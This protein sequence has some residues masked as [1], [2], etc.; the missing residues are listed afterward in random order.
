MKTKE[1]KMKTEK[2]MAV[3]CG[4]NFG[5]NSIYEKEATKLGKLLAEN[6]I[7]L[8]YG[9]GGTG[10]M[11]AVA[12]SVLNNNGDAIGIT[13]K[14]IA[15]KE[16]PIK[17]IKTEIANN[18]L[19]RKARMIEL[20][21]AFCILPGGIGTLNEVTDILTMHQIKETNRAIYFLNTKG[22]WNLF[23]DLLKNMIKE[24]FLHNI[25]EYNIQI[26]DTPEEI[27]NAYNA[28]FFK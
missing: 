15:G 13:T 4:A 26:L 5:N 16:K 18:L 3:Y 20:S 27:I 28:R 1:K 6:S 11:G 8:V 19:T 14:L 24:G 9:G 23:G 25:S 7:K 12:M 22:Y 21:D 2:S 10:L 17:E